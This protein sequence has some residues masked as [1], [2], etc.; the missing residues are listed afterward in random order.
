MQSIYKRLLIKIIIVSLTVS[1]LIGIGAFLLGN[2]DNFEFKIIISTFLVGLYSLSVLASVTLLEKN[3][4]LKILAI[5]GITLSLISFTVNE[6]W[7]WEVF[8]SLDDAYKPI[9][10]LFTLTFATAHTCLVL[11]LIPKSKAVKVIQY[12]TISA[13][14]V[15]ATVLLILILISNSYSNPEGLLRVLGIAA[16]ISATGTVLGPVVNR[17]GNR[18]SSVESKFLGIATEK[19]TGRKYKVS[20]QK[21]LETNEYELIVE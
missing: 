5:V 10:S 14:S 11:L 13:I 16:I 20:R 19:S 1:A 7:I 6:M 21:N 8:N 15:V 17:L 3:N 2:F 4:K 18:E 9:F 12:F